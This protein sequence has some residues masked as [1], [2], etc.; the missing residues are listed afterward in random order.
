[1]IVER[2]LAYVGFQFLHW[3]IQFRWKSGEIMILLRHSFCEKNK[4][5]RVLVICLVRDSDHHYQTCSAA[6]LYVLWQWDQKVL[7]RSSLVLLCE[8]NV[9]ITIYEE[10][11]L[12]SICCNSPSCLLRL[13]TWLKSLEMNQPNQNWKPIYEETPALSCLFAC[14][15]SLLPTLYGN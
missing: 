14:F 6:S 12:S 4:W 9:F 2:I 8:W 7:A 13:T 5:L 3:L 11:G 10:K 1:M 15:S